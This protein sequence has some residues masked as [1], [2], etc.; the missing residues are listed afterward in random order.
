MN[1][2]QNKNDLYLVGEIKRVLLNTSS[3]WINYGVEPFIPHHLHIQVVNFRFFSIIRLSK[4]YSYLMQYLNPLIKGI[5]GYKSGLI[6]L[7]ENEATSRYL[8]LMYH[9][10]VLTLS[11]LLATVIGYLTT[12][13]QRK[14]RLSFTINA[15][16]T[17]KQTCH[18]NSTTETL[19]LITPVG[20]DYSSIIVISICLWTCPQNIKERITRVC[21]GWFMLHNQFKSE[22]HLLYFIQF[23]CLFHSHFPHLP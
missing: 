6:Y 16:L 11:R 14:L 23:K 8:H 3:I 12:N 1:T 20:S 18:Q 22:G 13:S 9:S 4:R 5:L 2:N 10:N 7:P 15:V 17:L 21:Y 19:S